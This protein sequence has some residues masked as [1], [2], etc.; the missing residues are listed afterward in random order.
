VANRTT[1][2]LALVGV[3]LA[4]LL[5]RR[6]GLPSAFPTGALALCLIVLLLCAPIL[7]E[8]LWGLEVSVG[9]AWV[10]V[11]VLS[12]PVVGVLLYAPSFCHLPI[13]DEDHKD[14]EVLFRSLVL[15]VPLVGIFALRALWDAVARTRRTSQV[16]N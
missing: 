14:C 5:V 10:V 13:T 15:G 9:V 16:R 8:R 1:L 2:V 3:I 6:H 7:A 11:A 4:G 12:A